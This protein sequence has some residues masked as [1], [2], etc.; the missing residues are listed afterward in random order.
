MIHTADEDYWTKRVKKLP[1]RSWTEIREAWGQYVPQAPILDK[2]P[3]ER[4]D[5]FLATILEPAALPREV[6]GPPTVIRED[7]AGM[8]E[9]VLSHAVLSIHRAVHLL[10][11][12]EVHLETGSLT[13]AYT[14]AYHSAFFGMRSTLL[15]LGIVPVELHGRYVVLDLWSNR[16]RSKVGGYDLGVLGM[17]RFEQRQ[18]WR[19][20]QRMLRVVDDGPWDNSLLSS[21][22]GL[23]P[24]DFA[25]QRNSQIYRLDGA[26][27]PELF[28]LDIAD[29]LVVPNEDTLEDLSDPEARRFSF[30]L[31]LALVRFGQAC[32]SDI[33]WPAITDLEVLEAWCAV[34]RRKNVRCCIGLL[35][36]RYR[37]TANVSG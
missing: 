28:R 25:R 36:K 32:V 34:E 30:A 27:V 10:A 7:L 20:F 8:R 5:A 11:A 12:A 14:S 18:Q 24:S 9:G 4:L 15:F 1:G 29:P 33:A 35:D 21:L 16:R 19:I 17:R 23:E 31:A 37:R 3:A 13:W 22:H 2:P 26:W 6:S